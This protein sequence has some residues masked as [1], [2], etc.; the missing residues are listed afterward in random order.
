[1][2]DP[3]TIITADEVS[4][5]IPSGADGNDPYRDPGAYVRNVIFDGR[6][7]YYTTAHSETTPVSHAAVAADPGFTTSL[8]LNVNGGPLTIFS[9]TT[10]LETVVTSHV[11][12]NH[13]LGYVPRVKVSDELGSLLPVGRPIQSSPT[14]GMAAY[15]TLCIRATTTQVILDDIA[16]PG[17]YGL[18]AVSKTYSVRCF[19]PIGPVAGQP[20]FLATASMA[21][22][23]HGAVDTAKKSLRVA[24]G[25]EAHVVKPLGR[26]TDWLDGQARFVT[27]DGTVYDTNVCIGTNEAYP[28]SFAGAPLLDVVV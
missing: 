4:V 20:G 26:A 2:T 1:M 8:V 25:S 28:G 9:V 7:G 22:M 11:I 6:F 14:N 12:A 19:Q 27:G 23:A 3:R 18:P 24:I 10:F 15:R 13:N 5:F 17:E 16:Y 21:E